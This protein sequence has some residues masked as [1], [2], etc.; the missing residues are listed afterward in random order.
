MA[1]NDLFVVPQ[2]VLITPVRELSADVRK[3]FTCA[4][5]DFVLTRPKS[6]SRARIIDADGAQLLE[7]F[8]N[9]TAIVPAILRFSQTRKA[10]P[11]EVLDKAYPLLTE[12]TQAGFLVSPGAAEA[13]RIASAFEPGDSVAGCV[14]LSSVQI[15]DDTE[16]YQVLDADKR[17]CAL[18]RVRSG[19]QAG[20]AASLEREAFIL[21]HLAGA[22]SPALYARGDIDGAAYLLLEW[23][24]GAP[25]TDV[26]GTFLRAD[27]AGKLHVLACAILE[28]YAQLHARGVVHGDIHPRNILVDEQGSVRLIDFGY[29]RFDPPRE[30]FPEP[31]RGGIGFF[32]DPA[33]V[34]AAPH[35][36]PPP[37]DRQGE[38]YSLAA[39]LYLLFTGAPYLDFALEREKVFR[40]I[41]EDDPL[42]FARRGRN[43]WPEV[44]RV[45]QQALRKQPAERF[46]SVAAFAAALRSGTGSAQTHSLGTPSSPA[47]ANSASGLGK[48]I[49][50]TVLQR[51]GPAGPLLAAGLPSPPTTS[52]M[53]G[54]AGVAYFFYRLACLRDD[55]RLLATADLWCNRATREIGRPD[56]F[57]DPAWPAAEQEVAPASLYFGSSGVFFVQALI[58]QAMGDLHTARVAVKDYVAAARLPCDRPDLTL[59]RTSALIGCAA[60][61]E[62]LPPALLEGSEIWDLGR[63]VLASTWAILETYAP[64]G[65]C[66]PLAWLGI[67][68]GWAGLLHG[69]LRWCQASR[70]APPAAVLTRLHELAACSRQVGGATSWPRSNA[71]RPEG[72]DTWVGWCNGSAGYIHLWNLA[73][74]VF[75]EARFERLAESAAQHV[76]STAGQGGCDLC[77]GLGGQAYGLLNQYRNSGDRTW[78]DRARSLA[79]RALAEAALGR[80]KPSCLYKGDGGLAL[81]AAELEQPASSCMPAFEPEGWPPRP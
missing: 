15:L 20:A 12:L 23:C 68:H 74:D 54:S 35:Q 13:G 60:L 55:A 8:R 50:E 61:V 66:K 10:D 44:E 47:D 26:A 77:C 71:H 45:L 22:G 80:T 9:P 40:Q 62:A 57:H 37:A 29:A 59:G 49:L 1:V 30:G 63:E 67:A 11:K 31:T 75:R 51:L 53:Y 16:V 14:V 19:S 81:L 33:F 70:S 39:L 79:Q 48:E 73:H 72:Q 6:R 25:C 58:A 69:T 5:S 56:A 78:L 52:L 34:R 17:L 28:A 21:Q 42:P 76:W 4:E 32:F 18:K 3:Q 65:D 2:G 36:Q 41:A 38:Q 24:E 46:P 64:V 27:A 43:P 7:E